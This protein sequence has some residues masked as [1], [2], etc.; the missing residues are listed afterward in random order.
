[1]SDFEYEDEFMLL[2]LKEAEIALK[3]GEVPIGCVFVDIKNKRILCQGSNLVNETKNPT[4]HA[5][6]I[7]IDQLNCDTLSSEIA[8]YV[9]CEPC[10]MCASALNNPQLNIKAIFYGCSNPRFGGCGTVLNVVKVENNKK[11]I[12]VSK[13]HRESEAIDLLKDFYKGENPNAPVDKRK[14]KK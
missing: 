4:K 11:D 10:I 2:A 14:V 12:F 9:N 13:G 3:R 1:M 7:C 8:V 6:F 5:E